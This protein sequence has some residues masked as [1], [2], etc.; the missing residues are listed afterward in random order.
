V[1]QSCCRIANQ[2]YCQRNVTNSSRISQCIWVDAR[3]ALFSST[4]LVLKTETSAD[5]DLATQSAQSELDNWERLIFS[6]DMDKDAA[7]PSSNRNTRDT[8]S[9]R[10]A[11][12]PS[13]SATGPNEGSSSRVRPLLKSWL[14]DAF[15]LTTKPGAK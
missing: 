14:M 13:T 2:A 11:G 15:N 3:A 1:A 5:P 10:S 12:Q 4:M 8:R 7:G 6:F 9:S